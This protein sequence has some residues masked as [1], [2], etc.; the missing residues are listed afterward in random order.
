MVRIFVEFN[1][2]KIIVTVVVVV[3]LLLSNCFLDII[4][5]AR[6]F[7]LDLIVRNIPTNQ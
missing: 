6:Q 7:V 1:I 3:I 5:S 2:P 4:L